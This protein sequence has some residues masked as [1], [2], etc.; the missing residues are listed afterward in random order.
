MS[1]RRRNYN[2]ERRRREELRKARQAAKQ[3]RR[4]ERD[5]SGEAGPEMGEAQDTGA[6]TG[7]WEWFSPSR[8][9]TLATAPNTRPPDDPP[10]DWILLTD[11]PDDEQDRG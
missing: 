5:A 4:T 7:L 11:V 2:F 6:P 1:P 10:N 3:A 9:R 8:T